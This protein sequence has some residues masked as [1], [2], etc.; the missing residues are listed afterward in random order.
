MTGKRS[1]HERFPEVIAAAVRVF[2]TDGYKVG[3]DE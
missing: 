1:A 2:A 3:A